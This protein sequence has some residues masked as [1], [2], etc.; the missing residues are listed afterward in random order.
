MDARRASE[1]DG[2][3]ARIGYP[4][5]R[6]AGRSAEGE[7]MAAWSGSWIHR[8]LLARGDYRRVATLIAELEY[9][10]VS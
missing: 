7:S 4:Q 8:R 1:H 2:A 3:K 9:P 5:P 6:A 10:G